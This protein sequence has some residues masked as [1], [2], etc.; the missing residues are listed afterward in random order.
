VA[1]D[2]RPQLYIF[3]LNCLFSFRRRHNHSLPQCYSPRHFPGI[4]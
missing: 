3:F 2:F 1:I 4:K